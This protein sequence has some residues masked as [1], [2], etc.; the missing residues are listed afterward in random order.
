MDRVGPRMA[1]VQAQQMDA[2][3]AFIARAVPC[4]PFR[5]RKIA[6]EGIKVAERLQLSLATLP[7]T[8]ARRVTVDD[9]KEELALESMKTTD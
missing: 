7:F 1:I 3:R 4:Q 9:L 8:R 2:Q 5:Y 6:E